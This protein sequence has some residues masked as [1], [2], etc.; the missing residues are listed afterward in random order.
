MDSTPLIL[1]IDTALGETHLGLFRGEE[2]LALF[3]DI[4]FKKQSGHLVAWIEALLKEAGIAYGDLT[5]IST[6]TGP[7]GFTSIRIG[8]ATAR[9]LAF[10]LDIHAYGFTTLQ[11]MA[12]A[13]HAH[14]PQ[15]NKFLC[16][17]PGGREQWFAQAFMHGA[18][19]PSPSEEPHLINERSF[20]EY[21]QKYEY[22]VIYGLKEGE[23]HANVVIH[24]TATHAP[25]LARLALY[26]ASIS[27]TAP[28]PVYI[29][30]PDATPP[31]PRE[32]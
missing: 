4:N 27:E 29:R 18:D 28:G 12:T 14:I 13:N 9:A 7:G 16:L 3:H 26:H 2:Q 6:T 8:L 21:K 1:T 30:P 25:T 10:A 31:R 19:A 5:A 15:G 23:S 22:S 20:D 17:L 32:S 11:L 24:D